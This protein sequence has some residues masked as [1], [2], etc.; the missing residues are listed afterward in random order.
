MEQESEVVLIVTMS[1]ISLTAN[2]YESV[3]TN[4]IP[5]LP[6]PYKHLSSKRESSDELRCLFQ[7]NWR[8]KEASTVTGS[9]LIPSNSGYS[10]EVLFAVKYFFSPLPEGLYHQR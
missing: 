9:E 3:A 4:G 1:G 2:R 10:S 6:Q 5:F 7:G 8:G